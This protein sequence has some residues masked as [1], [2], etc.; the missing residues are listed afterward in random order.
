MTQ[1]S[2]SNQIDPAAFRYVVG[3]DIG[4]QSCS[5]CTLKPDKQLVFKP[6]DFANTADGFAVLLEK[7]DQLGVPADQILVG[8][9]A[10]SRYGETLYHLLLS[11]GY[12]LCLLHPAQ[13]HHFAQQRS[14][15]AKTDHLDTITIARLLLSGEAR[16]GYVPTELVAAYRELVRLHTQ[17]SDE[18]AR[19]RNEI[20]ALLVVQFA[21]IQ[22]SLHR[23]LS[24][25]SS[26]S[27]QR[28]SQPPGDPDSRSGKACQPSA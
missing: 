21:S 2:S 15:R 20:H 5:M 12:H 24:T 27:T 8:L 18:V 1:P 22:P 6:T 25:D 9:E 3:I 17:L 11:R 23:P 19:Y 7:L 26:G 10:T 13:T 28:L 14:L 16:Q 4:S